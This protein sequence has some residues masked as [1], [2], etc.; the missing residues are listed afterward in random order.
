LQKEFEISKEDFKEKQFDILFK[1]TYS[2]LEYMK[3]FYTGEEAKK[4][5]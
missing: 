4:M 1:N 2:Q 5:D 3:L